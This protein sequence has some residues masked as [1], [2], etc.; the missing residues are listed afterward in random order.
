MTGGEA[1]RQQHPLVFP[2][3]I[4]TLLDLIPSDV[5]VIKGLKVSRAGGFEEQIETAAGPE[6]PRT[7]VQR[8][9]RLLC[10]MEAREEKD[11]IEGPVFE[12]R[13]FRAGHPFPIE[14]GTEELLI[15]AALLDR[16]AGDVAERHCHIRETPLEVGAEKPVP[17]S[18]L[19]Y[20]SGEAEAETF[21]DVVEGQDRL[22]L[23]YVEQG[24]I[25]L[26]LGALVLRCT[27][28]RVLGRLV[29]IRAVEVN[30]NRDY[31]VNLLQRVHP[32]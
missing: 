23:P 22:S 20:T 8:S 12:G 27:E 4:V 18:E 11:D 19:E 26:G 2:Y 3:R 16:V 29:L 14:P 7:F 9:L 21:H 30:A 6:D 28:I 15:L 24:P 1:G 31:I 32:L 13:I 25:K 5:E 10:V 17:A